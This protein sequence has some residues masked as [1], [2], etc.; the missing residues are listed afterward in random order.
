MVDSA[1]CIRAVL[2]ANANGRGDLMLPKDRRSA[3]RRYEGKS[4]GQ[5]RDK[6]CVFRNSV[7]GIRNSQSRVDD[8]A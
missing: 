8:L 7:I 1:R 3:R 2:S 5:F 6:L 4:L